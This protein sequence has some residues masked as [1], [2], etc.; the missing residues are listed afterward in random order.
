MKLSTANQTSG[1]TSTLQP[2]A[3]KSTSKL[4]VSTTNKAEKSEGR[5]F[6]ILLDVISGLTAA[7]LGYAFIF[8][9]IP[10]RAYL[11]GESFRMAFYLPP[12]VFQA[13]QWE[14]YF[15]HIN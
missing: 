6:K 9:Y 15:L 7:V 2:E 4:D 10:A 14:N 12:G 8:L 5:S 1:S 3:E 13:T 11:V